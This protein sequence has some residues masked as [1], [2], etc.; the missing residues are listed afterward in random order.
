M[1]GV[2]RVGQR[3]GGIHHDDAGVIGLLY[4]RRYG[5]S[6]DGLEDDHIHALGDEIL[7]IGDL[8]VDVVVGIIDVVFFHLGIALQEG[9]QLID[10]LNAIGVAYPHV[11]K[12]D[13]VLLFLGYSAGKQG[14]YQRQSQDHSCQFL[15]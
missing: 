5:F 1:I 12:T 2:G 6:G 15:H 13:G 10:T 11:G 14:Q 3:R 8:L 7:D 9:L 4:H